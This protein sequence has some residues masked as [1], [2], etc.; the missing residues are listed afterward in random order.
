MLLYCLV[1]CDCRRLIMGKVV[2]SETGKPLAG[3]T[4][5]NLNREGETILTDPTGYFEI[6]VIA[7]GFN[8]PELRI[9]V[10][11]KGYQSQETGT[12][13]GDEQTIRLK[14]IR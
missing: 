14:R 10:E 8:C 1:S 5:Y 6:S 12:A 13:A 7:S 3:A 2:D 4:V 9:R 11:S